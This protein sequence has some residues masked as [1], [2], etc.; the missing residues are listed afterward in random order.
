VV[1]DVQRDAPAQTHHHDIARL[2]IFE[3][4]RRP[5]LGSLEDFRH[6]RRALNGREA[7]IGHDQ[8]IGFF[9]HFFLVQGLENFSEVLVRAFN[10]GERRVGSRAGLVLRS[11]RFA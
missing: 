10:P 9:P 2:G 6:V 11:I 3:F 4:F 5:E 1:D 7:V 8:D